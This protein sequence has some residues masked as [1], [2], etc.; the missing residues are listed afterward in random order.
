MTTLP[1]ENWTWLMR[2]LLVALLAFGGLW[3]FLMY[4]NPKY[5]TK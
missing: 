4:N 3:Y 1:L 5:K 2:A